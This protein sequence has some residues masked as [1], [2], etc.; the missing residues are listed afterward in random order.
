MPLA[1]PRTLHRAIRDTIRN[2]GGTA[3]D[4]TKS[5]FYKQ[6][7]DKVLPFPYVVYDL[8]AS[9]ALEPTFEK[10]YT[11]SFILTVTVVGLEPD[12]ED[13]S[14][15][16]LPGSV[17]R[18]LDSLQ[19]NPDELSGVGHTCINFLRQPGWALDFEQALRGPTGER[20]WFGTAKYELVIQSNFGGI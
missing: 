8:A 4:W 19:E 7:P 15:P 18:Y 13:L 11:E 9:S 20:V 14:S 1:E 5:P 10:T 12:I 6:V 2:V 16:Y 17:F 3:I